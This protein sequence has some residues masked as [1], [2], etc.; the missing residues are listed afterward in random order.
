LDILGA[1]RNYDY[2][3]LTV[4][5]WTLDDGPYNAMGIDFAQMTIT[6]EPGTLVL[7]SIGCLAVIRRRR[8]FQGVS[9]LQGLSTAS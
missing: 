8:S 1:L 5:N 9:A 2:T 6:P 3:G 7:L 4:F